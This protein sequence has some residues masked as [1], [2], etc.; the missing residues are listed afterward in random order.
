M[1][2]A[3]SSGRG[4]ASANFALRPAGEL[5]A[6]SGRSPDSLGDLVEGDREDVVQ[7]ERDPL[8]RAEPTQHLEQCVA[9]LVVERHAVG[10][11]G[12]R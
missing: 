7:D 12:R 10:G 8:P 9:D 6:R 1:R 4:V 3:G 11:I 2:G 5:P